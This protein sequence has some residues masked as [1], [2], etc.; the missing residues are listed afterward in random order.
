MADGNKYSVRKSYF[1]V[2]EHVLDD[3]KN[4][5]FDY[6]GELFKKSISSIYFN[7]DKKTAILTVF[8]GLLSYIIDRIKMI[9]KFRNY[10]VK[11]NDIKIR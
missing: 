11:K 10:A 4:T 3:I 9:K 6:H 5:G 7:D 8:D 2:A 1:E